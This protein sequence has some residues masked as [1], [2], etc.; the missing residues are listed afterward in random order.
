VFVWQR[1]DGWAWQTER[2]KQPSGHGL[3]LKEWAVEEAE[4]FC[5]KNDVPFQIQFTNPDGVPSLNA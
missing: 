5:R 2:D 3:L 4:H 1:S